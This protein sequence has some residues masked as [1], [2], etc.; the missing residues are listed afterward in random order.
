MPMET[1]TFY[2]A[3]VAELVALAGNETSPGARLQWLSMAAYWSSL[4]VR[5]AA[6]DRMIAEPWID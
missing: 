1:A 6:G 3:K 4:G 5:A 2:Q